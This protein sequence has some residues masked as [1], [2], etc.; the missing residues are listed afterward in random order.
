MLLAH[1]VPG[2]FAAALSQPRWQ[3]HWRT[4]QRTLLW[5]VALGIVARPLGLEAVLAPVQSN[6]LGY[7]CSRLFP[8]FRQR[9][10]LLATSVAKFDM[11][12]GV[13]LFNFI[14]HVQWLYDFPGS[15][16]R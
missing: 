9:F 16:Y 3:S 4:E 15:L 7:R 1:L 10:S 12:H 2:Y 5:I 8:V 13:I 14:D 11:I 6:N